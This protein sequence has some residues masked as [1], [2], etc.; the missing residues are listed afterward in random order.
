MMFVKEILNPV[1]NSIEQFADRNAFMIGESYYTYRDFGLCI[2]KVRARIQESDFEGKN[3][4]LMANDDLETYASIFAIWLEGL[5][6][7]P[8]HPSY[9][10][11]RGQGI[12]E[13]AEIGLFIDSSL[14]CHYQEV[15]IIKSKELS[16][17]ELNLVPVNTN[18]DSLAYIL[19]TSG[20]TGKPKGVP[21]TRANLVAFMSAFWQIGFQVDETDKC[22]QYFDLS[23]DISIQSYLVPLQKGACTYTVGHDKIKPTY[24]VELLEDHELTFGATPPSM[25]RFL[26]PYF[27][28]IDLPHL[29]CNILCAEASALDLIKEWKDCIPNSNIYNLYGPTEATIYC[30]Y[31]EFYQNKKNKHLNGMLS[32][33]KPLNGVDILVVDEDNKEVLKGEKGELCVSGELVTKGYW[34][35]ELKNEE[36]FFIELYNGKEKRFYKTG[37][38]CFIDSDSDIMLSGRLDYQVKVQGYRIELGEIEHLAREFSQGHNAVAVIFDNRL[39]HTEIALFIEGKID[40][41]ELANY[42]KTKLPVYMCPTKLICDIEFP[43]NINGKVDRPQL[44]KLV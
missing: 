12:I 35:N 17:C 8:I 29:K 14:D 32:I 44:R 5:A 27:E 33:G 10:L 39:G 1:L 41:K 40:V 22:L 15:V 16:D 21:I 31:S 19:F 38:L 42:L 43:L 23:F 13:E 28:E 18:E 37:D 34:K 7:V 24:T 30:T 20:S 4:G 11:D 25:I 3:V 9:P 2:S 36:A 6:Y 26:R